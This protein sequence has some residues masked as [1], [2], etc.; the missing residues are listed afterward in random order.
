MPNPPQRP[1]S[2]E[3]I[4]REM[5]QMS[6]GVSP[7]GETKKSGSA[8]KSLMDF[9]IKVEPEEEPSSSPPPPQFTAPQQAPPRRAV[10]TGSLGV[11]RPQQRVGDLV[12]SEP[13]PTFKPPATKPGDDLAQ[14]EFAQIY[15]DAG[16]ANSPCSVD[17]LAQLMDN[18]TVANQPLSVKIIAVNLALSA[19]NLGI[20]VPIAD[21]ARRDRALDAYQKMLTDRAN[22]IEQRNSEKVQLISK[23]V[24]EYLKR[25]QAE[26]EALKTEVADARRQSIDFAVRREAEEKRLAE[27]ISPFL[28]GKPNPVTVGN[29]PD[30]PP[31]ENKM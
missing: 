25:K 7:S 26:M 6:Q 10:P 23:E 14:R 19:K 3:D 8:F 12:A 1:K 2:T 24:E 27:L 5:E 28:E 31:P 4:L 18:P 15:K 11:P 13:P 20:D 16:I 21:A 29:S 22:G 30:A 9:F 17:E